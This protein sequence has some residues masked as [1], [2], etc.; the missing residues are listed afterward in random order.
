MRICIAVALIILCYSCKAPQA[1]YTTRGNFTVRH[2]LHKASAELPEFVRYKNQVVFEITDVNPYL[3]SIAF[4]EMQQDVITDLELSTNKTSATLRG[5]NFD[6]ESIDLKSF[7]TAK[8]NQEPEEPVLQNDNLAEFKRLEESLKEDYRKRASLRGEVVD[9]EDQLNVLRNDTNSSTIEFS[10]SK[11]GELI[12]KIKLKKAAVSSVDQ[13]ISNSEGQ[14]TELIKSMRD[15]VEKIKLFHVQLNNYKGLVDELRE[16]V[17]FYNDLQ[18]L[19]H[20]NVSYIE[21][22]KGKNKLISQY[23]P[24][25]QNI[26]QYCTGLL[27]ELEREYSFCGDIYYTISDKSKVSYLMNMVRDY[28]SKIRQK[29]F[30]NLFVEIQSLLN[31]VKPDNWKFKYQT[32]AISDKADKISYD[33]TATPI[34]NKYSKVFYPV[35]YNYNFHVRGG[36]KIDVSAGLFWNMGMFDDE[37]SLKEVGDST[38]VFSLSPT[39]GTRPTFGTLFNIY[40]RSNQQIKP[41]INVG[42]GTDIEKVYYYFGGGLMLGRSERVSL[43]AGGVGGVVF[44]IPNQY[45]DQDNTI[46][47]DPIDNVVTDIQL[48]ARNEFKIG[49]FIGVSY[50]LSGKNRGTMENNI[51]RKNNVSFRQNSAQQ[52]APVEE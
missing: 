1:T 12:P 21:I 37:F 35:N 38:Q 29:H 45:R 5:A 13:K 33:F 2:S 17:N 25:T 23:F 10:T 11:I 4:S 16:K 9:L 49:W 48:R 30:N 18:V 6:I 39:V 46:F 15:D 44:R 42:L 24:N 20:T 26:F 31:S 28:H 7:Q 50:N 34:R 19:L 36:V 14:K 47:P 52:Q 3:Y 51:S 41:S 22:E 40:R 32:T 27:A 43:N 8:E